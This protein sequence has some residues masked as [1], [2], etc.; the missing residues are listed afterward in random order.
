MANYTA[1]PPIVLS[2]GGSLIAPG[3]KP[4]TEFLKDLNDFVRH[5]V[6]KGRRFFLVAGGG[7][8]ARYYRDAGKEVIGTLTEE[9]LDWLGIHATHLNGHLLR[10]IFQ[11][12]AHPRVVQDYNRKLSNWVEPVVIGAGW[13]PGWS[14]DYDAVLLARD[15]G[16]NLIVNMSNI[17]YVYTA[18][19]RQ[20]KD[21]KPIKSMTW[22]ELEALVGKEWRPGLNAPFDPV[23]SSLAKELHLRVIITDGKDFKNLHNIIENKPFKGTVIAPEVITPEYYDEDYFK[24]KKGE[25]K[26]AQVGNVFGKYWYSAV[27]VYRALMIKWNL[28]PTSV[29]DVGCGV[30]YLV[31][32]LRRLGVDAHGVEVSED[33]LRLADPEVR[34][35]LHYGDVTRLP[36]EDNSFDAVVSF[37]VLEHIDASRLHKAVEETVRVA[38]RYVL[39]KVYTTENRY[40]TRF[41][42]RDFSHTSVFSKQYWKRHFATLK[43]VAISRSPFFHLP[44]YFETVFFLKKK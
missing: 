31:K 21:A 27:N 20:V 39:H 13:K 11:D 35:F 10:T 34:P 23:A 25:Y 43:N 18:D 16:A 36:Y 32:H 3:S 30:G 15:Y 38:K 6:S 19:P 22:G 1:D 42:R 12:I 33:A 2:V 41:H 26:V 37:D 9:D 44:E 24:G 5:W 14:T 28:N 7:K 4:D 40:I 8:I 17:D 29:L